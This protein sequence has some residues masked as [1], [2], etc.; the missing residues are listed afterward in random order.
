MKES[1]QI[2]E[3]FL[4]LQMYPGLTHNR[5]YIK[6]KTNY[7]GGDIFNVI[8]HILYL[9]Y[10][11]KNELQK[12]K[13]II[14]YRYKFIYR[15][16]K[17]IISDCTINCYHDKETIY[18]KCSKN[19][20]DNNLY[21]DLFLSEIITIIEEEYH[22]FDT[23]TNLDIYKK[24]IAVFLNT[25]SID[26]NNI[27]YDE[28]IK[29]IK[30]TD[31]WKLCRKYGGRIGFLFYEEINK[32]KPNLK[33]NNK[34][35]SDVWCNALD[36]SII[37]NI[38]KPK[39]KKLLKSYLTESYNLSINENDYNYKDELIVIIKELLSHYN[40]NKSNID[41]DMFVEK[42]VDI[43]TFEFL[44]LDSDNYI[45]NVKKILEDVL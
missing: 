28:L 18:I 35:F 4:L 11:E 8:D 19:D 37:I 39:L 12:D 7:I 14:M 27:N 38:N 43:D 22:N 31:L 16:V 13:Y 1:E 32:R 42:L 10:N 30:H 20:I 25:L 2:I 6:D 26:Y 3:N 41:I 45:Y 29:E 36:K 40:W 33:N 24:H 15:H 9:Y 5:L 17:V 44:Q 34:I 21:I 23:T